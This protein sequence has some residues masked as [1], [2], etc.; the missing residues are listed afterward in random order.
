MRVLGDEKL[1]VSSFLGQTGWKRKFCSLWVQL[2]MQFHKYCMLHSSI[3]YYFCE[4]VAILKLSHIFVVDCQ[5]SLY[6][7]KAKKACCLFPFSAIENS[8]ADIPVVSSSEAEQSEPDCDIG[9]TL[10]ADPQSEP[11]SFVSPPER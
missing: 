6:D 10:E 11:S 4:T 1:I 2:R 5:G 7:E 9:G 3:L 8:R